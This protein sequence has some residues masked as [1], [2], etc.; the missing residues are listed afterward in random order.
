MSCPGGAYHWAPEI[1]SDRRLAGAILSKC[2]LVHNC[3]H[4]FKMARAQVRAFRANKTAQTRGFPDNP[5][6]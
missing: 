4:S 5:V 6:A 3:A 1:P 2:E